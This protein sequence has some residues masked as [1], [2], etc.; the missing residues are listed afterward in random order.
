MKDFNKDDINLTMYF[1][2]I[3][4][5][6]ED[7]NDTCNNPKL[8]FLKEGDS[9]DNF[10][11]AEFHIHQFA[12]Y[13]GFMVR[14]GHVKIVDTAENSKVVRKRTILCKHSGIYKPKNTRKASTSA[15]I[16][17]PWHINHSC[18]L[19]NNFNFCVF[20]T[21]LDDNHNHDLSLKAIRFEKNKQFTEEM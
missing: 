20:V 4:Y 11:N 13:K 18:P 8:V 3:T 9:F 14:L 10:D 6:S 17:C 21:T 19:K 1:E 7:I 2:K 5:C 16:S 15:R 12:E